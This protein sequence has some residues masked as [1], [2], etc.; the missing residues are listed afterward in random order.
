[1]TIH[2]GIMYSRLDYNLF[3]NVCVRMR[4]FEYTRASIAPGMSS[5]VCPPHD[6]YITP[7]PHPHSHSESRHPDYMLQLY[8]TG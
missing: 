7:P 2:R 6:S 5:V 4:A 1:M 3:N 8:D